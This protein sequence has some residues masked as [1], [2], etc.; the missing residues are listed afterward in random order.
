MNKSMWKAEK[1]GSPALVA[2][3]KKR[4]AKRKT[5]QG[6]DP[7]HPRWDEFLFRLE[8]PEG[9]NFRKKAGKLV[10]ICGGG[11]DRSKAEAILKSMVSI[12]IRASLKYFYD[13]GGH[14]DCEILF[15]VATKGM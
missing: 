12:D 9:C 6:M 7:K 14:C 3:Q 5:K 11:T 10:W 4:I 15:N 13:N 8:G 1:L 2:A